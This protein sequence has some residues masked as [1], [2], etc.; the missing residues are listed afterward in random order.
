MEEWYKSKEITSLK[1][2]YCS[3]NYR[4]VSYALGVLILVEAG[5]LALCAAISFYY[6]EE[7]YIHFLQTLLIN[8]VLGGL[9]LLVGKRNE[10]SINRRDGY[11]IV[12]LSWLL[13]SALG[14]L[15]F[16]FS[17]HITSVA[18]AFFETMSGFTTTGATILDHIESLPPGLLFWRSLT[19]WIGGLGIVLFTIALLP[20]FSGSSQQLFLSEATGV[21]MT[22]FIPKSR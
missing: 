16:L 12:S 2:R 10:V 3:V 6:Q 7:E 21:P 1:S 18:D 14:M 11:C 13:F 8:V 22:R 5:L 20:L 4:H 17:G 15:P 9:M 19:Q